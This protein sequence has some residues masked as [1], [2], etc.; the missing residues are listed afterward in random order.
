MG[1]TTEGPEFESY[2]GQEFSLLQVVQPSSGARPAAYPVGIGG[3]FPGS[4]AAT[5]AEVKLHTHVLM[6]LCLIS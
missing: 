4:K 6:T 5:S 1:W 2:E 3:S